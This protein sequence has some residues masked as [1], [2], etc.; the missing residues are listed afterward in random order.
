MIIPGPPSRLFVAEPNPPLL[1]SRVGR[2]AKAAVT[3]F[4]QG[5]L[6]AVLGTVLGFVLARVE[7]LLD[8]M[9]ADR[10]RSADWLVTPT[11]GI[12]WILTNTGD[13]TATDIELGA[14]NC[15]LA[16]PTDRFTLDRAESVSVRV[17]VG[18]NREGDPQL[19]ISWTTHRDQRIGP[20]RR[21]LPL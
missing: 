20:V 15:Q 5:A 18:I 10:R 2:I 7:R 13:A 3:E 19:L 1:Q 12:T 21:L 16:S 6:I 4:Q 11:N 14:E 8:E 17:G 9:A